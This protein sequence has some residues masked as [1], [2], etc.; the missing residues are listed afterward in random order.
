MRRLIIQADE[1]LISRTRQ[2]A[3]RRGVS[4][5]QV[6]RDALEREIGNEDRPP[7]VTIVGA[8]SSRA[9]D[10]SRR[11]GDDEYEAEPYRS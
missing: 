9:G 8:A 10:L 1:D 5:A 3:R 4:M 2:H 7:A 11:A 6:V